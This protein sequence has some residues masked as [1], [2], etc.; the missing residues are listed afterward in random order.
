MVA[1]GTCATIALAVR[2]RRARFDSEAE[3]TR[4][5]AVSLNRV[6]QP[7]CPHLLAAYAVYAISAR[8][9]RRHICVLCKQVLSEDSTQL[10]YTFGKKKTS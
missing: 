9:T 3:K 2:A 4:L 8:S 6:H 7:N 1:V 5:R 10:K